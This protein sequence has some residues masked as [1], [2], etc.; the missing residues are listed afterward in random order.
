MIT[1]QKDG[2]NVSDARLM[3]YM[4]DHFGETPNIGDALDF[5]YAAE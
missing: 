1:P 5:F 2:G 4:D 3:W